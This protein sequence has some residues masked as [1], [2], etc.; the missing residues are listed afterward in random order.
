MPHTAEN[1]KNIVFGIIATVLGGCLVAFF[2]MYITG[3]ENDKKE[4]QDL[5]DRVLR[6]EIKSEEKKK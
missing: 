6:L 3:K 5:K 1:I 4:F 2:T